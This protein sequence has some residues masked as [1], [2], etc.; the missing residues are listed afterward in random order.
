MPLFK[1]FRQISTDVQL[2]FEGKL[3]RLL[4]I[5]CNALALDIG[6]VSQIQNDIYTVV[7]ATAKDSLP[8]GTQFVLGDTY[9]AHTL[10]ADGILAIQHTKLSDFASHPCYREFGLESYIGIPVFVNNNPYGTLNFSSPEPHPQ[11]FSE[12]DFDYMI[13]LAE[14]VGLEI[15]RQDSLNKVLTQ[16]QEAQRQWVLRDQ[17]SELAGLGTWEINV[18][19][20]TVNW[21]NALKRIHDLDESFVPTLTNVYDFPR[22][23]EDKEKL[24]HLFKKAMIDGESFSYELA[25]RTAKGRSRWIRAQAQAVMENG[26]CKYVIGASLDITNQIQVMEELRAQR[27][28]AENALAARSRFLANMSHEIRTPLNGVTGMLEVL[29]KTQLNIRQKS[30]IDII[31]HS[32]RNLLEIINDVLDFSKIDAGEMNLEHLP[33]NINVLVKQLHNVFSRSAD[34]K[35]LEFI[36]DNSATKGV[37]V[38]S[39]P[40]RLLQ[41]LNNLLSNAI[42]FTAQGQVRLT[43][44]VLQQSAGNI[45]LNIQVE[46]SGIG[47]DEEQQEFIF[48]PFTQA[49][50]DTTRKFGGTGLG[51][52]IV[53]QIIALMGGSIKVMSSPGKGTTFTIKLLL[54]L[55]PNA[56]TSSAKQVTHGKTEESVNL[57]SLRVLVVEDN[58]INQ[59]VIKEQLSEFGITPVVADNGAEALALIK[60]RAPVL[61]FDVIFM[62]CQ[63]PM[64]DGYTATRNIR[65]LGKTCKLI[66]IIA[67]TANAFSEERVRCLESGM[68]DYLT[69]PLSS[70]QLESSLLEVEANIGK[71]KPRNG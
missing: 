53:A 60:E 57:S 26:K 44:R 59:L 35:G 33:V 64:M 47:I 15:S 49:D 37:V 40:T 48:S 61:D 70:K 63:M 4:A 22:F 46:D 52:S 6:I 29:A 41:V 19:E 42:K 39:D 66:P 3:E 9:C 36:V 62:D 27:I 25:I 24:S 68:T 2:S 1:A 43:T 12:S 13:L 67:L 11:A 51:L 30:I 65:E 69:K 31:K 55:A 50:T 20:G 34:D 38:L 23:A 8:A 71:V 58:L 56:K 14:W 54:Q 10:K 7:A 17:M 5:G 18:S 21:S 28:E 45:Q 16:Q 32:A